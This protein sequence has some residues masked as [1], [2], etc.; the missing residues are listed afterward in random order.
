[1]V[2]SLNT[3][4]GIPGPPAD[5]EQQSGIAA[6]LSS[7][8]GK[9]IAGGAAMLVILGI[10]AGVLFMFVMA[11]VEPELVVVPVP[12]SEDTTGTAGSAEES[13]EA[14]PVKPIED[15]FTF[16]NIMSPTV[17]PNVVIAPAASGEASPSPVGGTDGGDGGPGGTQTTVNPEEIPPNTLYLYSI[18]NVDGEDMGTFIWNEVVYVFG[19]GQALPGTPWKVLKLEGNTATMLY[20]DVQV[21]LTAGQG[22]TK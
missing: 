4:P 6:F 18:V 8:K 10:L 22:I 17:K 2:D 9:L 3:E 12:A 14:L 13:A 15:T 11:D 5:G 16:R 19:E 21:T 20:G 7:T 1:M